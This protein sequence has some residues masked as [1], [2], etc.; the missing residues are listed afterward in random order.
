[1]YEPIHI[2]IR[3]NTN[4]L[5]FNQVWLQNTMQHLQC[6]S[7][8]LNNMHLFQTKRVVNNSYSYDFLIEIESITN[9]G[10]IMIL[11]LH[12]WIDVLSYINKSTNHNEHV[13]LMKILSIKI[14]KLQ[15][16]SKWYMNPIVILSGN[17]LH[18]FLPFHALF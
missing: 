1:M 10:K 11:P 9:I 4:V 13:C 3:C 5:Y 6:S 16:S 14:I 17:L 12:M 18:F 2:H 15:L 8:L 7:N